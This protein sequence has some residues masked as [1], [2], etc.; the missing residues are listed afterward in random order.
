MVHVPMTKGFPFPPSPR[1]DLLDDA[2]EE[3]CRY[4][5]MYEVQSRLLTQQS[6]GCL[7][8][9]MSCP[10]VELPCRHVSFAG[11]MTACLQV[12]FA[13]AFLDRAGGGKPSLSD[14]SG[15]R[16]GILLGSI[17]ILHRRPPSPP[18]PDFSAFGENWGSAWRC[19]GVGT[20]EDGDHT[21]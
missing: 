3:L 5:R 13:A 18:P 20:V 16:C 19:M 17:K 12:P 8:F 7:L 10:R 14:A 15:K 6:G 21:L 9:G 1:F 4:L 2:S 11:P